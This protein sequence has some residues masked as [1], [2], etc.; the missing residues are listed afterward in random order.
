MESVIEMRT[1]TAKE[2]LKEGEGKEVKLLG[3]L[4]WKSKVGGVMFCR[5]RDGS[6]Y[7]Q[8]SAKKGFTPTDVLRRIEEAGIE[9]AIYACGKVKVDMRAPGGKEVLLNDFKVIAPSQDWPITK[10]AISSPSFLFDNRHL[11]I[12]GMRSIAIMR[13]RAEIIYST[14]D[15]FTSK[16]YILIQAPTIVKNAVEG[17]ATLFEL[18]YFGSKAYLSQS[19]QLYEEAAICA[20]EKVFILQPAYRAEKSKTAKHLS[21]F[22]MIEAE[23]A[24]YGLEEN[25]KVQ[26]ELVYH[27][28]K[29]VVERRKA[30]LETLKR[31]FKVPEPPFP[32]ITYDEARDIAEKKGV[33]FPW[34]EDITTEAERQI[35]SY[36]DKPVFITHFPLSAR[37][38]YHKTLDENPKVTLSSDLFAPEGY[39]EI[40]TGGVRIEDYKTLKK[41]IKEYELPLESFEW[42]LELRR[43]GMP[44]HSGFG[45]GVERLLRWICNLKHIRDATL[46]PRTMLRVMP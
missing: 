32:R 41:R 18:D 23:H 22:W 15:Y 37:S 31:D 43:Y 30:E 5:L 39:G 33:G 35:S 34:G 16:G 7:I 28:A 27:I 24:F 2:A 6:G 26:E 19:A 12:R 9:S 46:F 17:G 14:I 3:W 42:Y 25:I 11:S 20:L 36:F 29:N 13:L 45:L 44:P 38:F 40:A 4:S 1:H 10:S 21:E 8:L